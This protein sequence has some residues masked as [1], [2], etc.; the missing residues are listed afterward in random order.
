MTQSLPKYPTFNLRL[1]TGIATYE[2]W[3][4]INIQALAQPTNEEYILI[5]G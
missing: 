1:G 5:L 4:H 3:G 2:F